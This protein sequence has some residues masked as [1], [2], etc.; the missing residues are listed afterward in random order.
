M[1]RSLYLKILL[2]WC[3]AL[4]VTEALIFVLFLF[5]VGE[6]HRQY[7]AKSVAQSSHVAADFLAASVQ[8]SLTTGSGE[9][10]ALRDAVARLAASSNAKVW[11]T[12]AAGE[13]LAASFPGGRAPE[14]ERIPKRTGMHDGVSVTIDPRGGF[15]WYAALP[16]SIGPEHRPLLLHLLSQRHGGT[17]PIGGFAGGLALI[18]ALV[19]LLAVP[20]TLRITRPLKRLEESALRIA[21]GDLSARAELSERDEIGRLARAFNHMAETAERMVRGGREL[22]AN[23]SHELRSPLARIR[24]AGECLDGALAR[25][26]RED[27]KEM[28]EAIWEDIEEADR[29]VG[30]ILRYARL[31]LQAPLQTGERVDVADVISALARTVGPLAK[32]RGISIRLALAAAEPVAGN[33][34]LLRIAFKNLLENAVL[35]GEPGAEV[36]VELDRREDD[37]ELRVTNDHESLDERELAD[38]FA[39]FYRG[40][41]A[42]A[43][44]SGLGLAI[45]RKIVALHQGRIEARNVPGAFQVRV[46]LPR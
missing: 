23:V 12:G 13:I 45:A 28:L 37:I 26:D 17:F 3:L 31:D 14:I 20:L 21:A 44:G 43:E 32:S 11:V 16:V 27:A 36:L 34:E 35:H 40:K 25:G 6:S 22:T 5:V 18:G 2:H 24:V 19:A 39:P 4:A 9:D 10:A 33:E 38:I 7:V 15:P 42:A 41:R 8:A 1:I 46:T 29:L 30:D